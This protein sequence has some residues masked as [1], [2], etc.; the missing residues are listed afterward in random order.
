[1]KPEEKEYD[2]FLLEAL[3]KVPVV[4]KAGDFISRI[5]KK[6]K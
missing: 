2:H 6:K 1:L 5:F 3:D 4:N